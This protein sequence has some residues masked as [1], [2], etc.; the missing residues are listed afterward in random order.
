MSD[1]PRNVYRDYTG[2]GNTLA[3]T[4]ICTWTLILDS[5]RYWVTE[6]HVDG[7]RFDLA[8]VLA[9]GPDGSFATADTSLL[10]AIRTDPILRH[11]HLIAEPWDA[12]WA[13][14]LGTQFPGPGWCQW[15]GRF[16]DDVRRFVRGD[17]GM[18]GAL[19]LRLYGSDDLFPDNP[20][21]VS[22]ALRDG[23]LRHL[24]RWL[25]TLRRRRLQREAEL[26]QWPRQRRRDIGQ[27]ELELRLGGG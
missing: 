4:S 18:V 21:D 24:P 7:F 11:V 22:P 12:G 5:L 15:N 14:Q 20:R 23:Q 1:D 13:Y 16:R 27:P 10:A 26:A 6:M 17:P 25:H 3:C 9:R 2:C 19:M 8:S